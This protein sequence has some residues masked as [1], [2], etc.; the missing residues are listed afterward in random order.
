MQ[1]VLRTIPSGGFVALP[2]DELFG[3]VTAGEEYY[4]QVEAT[5]PLMGFEVVEG[6]E[7]F[8]ALAAQLVQPTARLLVPHF[9]TDNQGNTTEIR[10]L[11]R[12]N[13]PV[14]VIVKAFGDTS[15][16]LAETEFQLDPGTLFV[17]EVRDLLLNLDLDLPPG[18][19]PPSK[20][21]PEPFEVHPRG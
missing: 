12:H 1:E 21:D 5:V 13:T 15:V 20:L 4:I 11:S 8:S 2:V 16:L 18:T 7:D 6:P 10:L 19:S 14:T 17:R 3:A 9:L